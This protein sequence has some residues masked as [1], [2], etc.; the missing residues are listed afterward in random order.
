MFVLAAMILPVLPGFLNGPVWQESGHGDAGSTRGGSQ[1]TESSGMMARISGGTGGGDREDMYL[2]R[3]CDLDAFL[4]STLPSVGGS[5]NFNTQL[6][7]FALD[8]INETVAYGLLAN[9]DA[10]LPPPGTVLSHLLHSSDDGS[11]AAIGAPGL[12]L[13]AISGFNRDALA[14]G[15]LPIFDQEFLTEISG[16]DGP[17]GSLPHV[18]WG[19]GPGETGTYMIALNGVVGANVDLPVDCN[20]NGV[21]D[22]CDIYFGTSLDLNGNRIPDECECEGDINGDLSVDFNDLLLL[23]SAWGTCGGC[24][25]DLDGDLIVGFADLLILLAN[26]GPC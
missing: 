21:A 6:W 7:I 24:P 16:P 19:V 20:G 22:N 8:E 26:W 18:A 3:I 9:D 5:A 23:L 14:T 12:Y 13:I 11:G 4:A 1:K 17:G 10:P 15:G 2:V 25:S